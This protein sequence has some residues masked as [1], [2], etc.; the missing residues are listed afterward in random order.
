[1][2]NYIREFQSSL[3]MLSS[4]ANAIPVEPRIE[5]VDIT[6]SSMTRVFNGY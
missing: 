1:M 5:I 4:A 6:K 3:D 2:L